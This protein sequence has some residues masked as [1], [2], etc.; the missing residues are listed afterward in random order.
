MSMKFRVAP[1][2]VQDLG[3]NLYTSLA[4]VLVE[5]VANAHDAD[6]PDVSIT[7][8]EE[9]IRVAREK[10][11]AAWAEKV[12]TLGADTAG[13]LETM[14]LPPDVQIVIEDKGVG[15]SRDELQ[16]KYLVIGRRKREAENRTHTEGGRVLMGRKGIG[17]LAGFGVAHKVTII[18]RK[19]GEPHSTRIVLDFNELIKNNS[20]EEVDVPEDKITGAEGIPTKGTRIVLSELISES[21]KNKEGTIADAIGD[22]FAMIGGD[23]AMKLNGV[24]VTPTQREFAYAYPQNDELSTD[25]LVEYVLKTE[26]GE[27]KFRYRIR[28]TKPKHQLPAR[29]RGVRIYAHNRLASAPDLLD[30]KTAIHGIN[31]TH[32]MDAVVFADFID[33]QKVDYIASNRHDLRWDTPLLVPFRAFLT[34]QMQDA[35]EAYQKS[36]EDAADKTVQEDDFTKKLIDNDRFPR[37]RKKIA[38]KIA[39]QIAAA[40]GDGVQSA[41]YKRALPAIVNGLQ[42]GE[43]VGAIAA[44]ARENIPNFQALISTVTELTRQEFDD[45]MGVIRA[46]L[47]GVH[48]LS[49]IYEGVDFKKGDNEKELHKLFENNPWLIDPTFTQFLTSN[50]SAKSL[51]ARLCKELKIGKYIPAGYD[52]KGAD[53]TKAEDGV[54]LRP[55]LVTL[56]SN[57][58]LHRVIII[59][60]KAPNTP[61]NGHHL[62]QLQNYMGLTRDFLDEQGGDLKNYKIEGYLIGSKADAKSR[63]E[64]VRWLRDQ[65]KQQQD[66]SDWKVFDIGEILRRT[67]QAH[68]QLL[69]IYE[70]SLAD[71]EK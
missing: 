57:D 51:N 48:A 16:S 2:I 47:D 6:S 66:T 11:K 61:L 45:F 29:E 44:L 1:H 43:I 13:P 36:K 69:D 20:T 64:E 21:A 46:R 30:I 17:K 35:I 50:A 26:H 68:R 40:Q 14:T 25:K 53:E 22:H 71:G 52:P 49:K 42:Q 67:S 28:F 4:R 58:G 55:D 41:F 70:K 63:A 65:I 59:E 31:N 27:K 33:D 34:E 39:G 18:S 19:E 62:R 9:K 60:L 38:Y 37:H 24:D 32:Y 56:L 10:L 15:M 12:K 54:N 8:D 5:L 7:L 23:F 3:L